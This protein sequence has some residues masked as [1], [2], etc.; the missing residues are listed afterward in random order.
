MESP[1]H[2]LSISNT[3]WLNPQALS[4]K[5][6]VE[7][8]SLWVHGLLPLLISAEFLGFPLTCP[9][10]KLI[11][12]LQRVYIQILVL[13]PPDSSSFLDFLHQF[14]AT[15]VTLKSSDTFGQ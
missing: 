7:E 12:D 5:W 15:P 10:L 11:K 2:F 13:P 6:A 3:T 1:R 4:L 8:I 14:P 9:L